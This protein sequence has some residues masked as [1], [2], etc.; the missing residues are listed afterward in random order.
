MCAILWRASFVL[1]LVQGLCHCRVCRLV[2]NIL[3]DVI[4]VGMMVLYVTVA[5]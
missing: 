1:L 5:F 4:Y 3:G 2:S